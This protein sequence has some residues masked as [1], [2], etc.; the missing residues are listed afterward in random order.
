MLAQTVTQCVE[1]VSTS[2][3]ACQLYTG[4]V[5]SSKQAV[6]LLSFSI[7][8]GNSS[9]QCTGMCLGPL[10]YNHCFWRHSPG[11]LHHAVVCLHSI[12]L[13]HWWVNGEYCLVG[14]CNWINYFLGLLVGSIES[15]HSSI[16]PPG[17]SGSG[18]TSGGAGEGPGLTIISQ[19]AHTGRTWKCDGSNPH[20]W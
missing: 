10:T 7:N 20:K 13:T 18:S 12:I 5:T 3:V 2:I 8:G 4:K 6:M 15:Y 9:V 16:S 11:I 17:D 19:T 1:Y 14:T